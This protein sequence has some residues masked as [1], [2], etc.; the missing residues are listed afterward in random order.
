MFNCENN[1]T[2]CSIS[3]DYKGALAKQAGTLKQKQSLDRTTFKGS[4]SWPVNIIVIHTVWCIYNSQTFGYGYFP[5]LARKEIGMTYSQMLEQHHGSEERMTN[6]LERG[7]LRK[8][9]VAE[10][11]FAYFYP[12]IKRASSP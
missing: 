1:L 3:Q 5:P 2:T 9:E 10:G 11:V 7:D 8:E 12:Q 4:K 6:A